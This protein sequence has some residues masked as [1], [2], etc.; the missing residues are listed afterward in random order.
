MTTQVVT[1]TA[2]GTA[3]TTP[4]GTTWSTNTAL[5]AIHTT[6]WLGLCFSPDLGKWCACETAAGH[7]ATSS[8]GIT[9]SSGGIL[10]GQPLGWSDICWSPALGKFCMVSNGHTPNA[11][12]SSDGLTWTT[13]AIGEANTWQKVAWSPSLNLFVAMANSGTHQLATSPDGVTW[14][15]VAHPMSSL[16]TLAWDPI[17][18]L[19]CVTCFST[20]KSATS[21][22]GS[23]WT[24]HTSNTPLNQGNNFDLC[25]IAGTGGFLCGEQGQTVASS[26]D[27]STWTQHA[28]NNGTVTVEALDWCA[29]LSKYFGSCSSGAT[30]GVISS[31]DGSTWATSGT[32]TT[33]ATWVN[34]AAFVAPPIVG[35]KHQF[36]TVVC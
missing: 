32:L 7:T 5:N 30:Q 16:Q 24:A 13:S 36:G 26:T 15:L 10:S 9:W 23:T 22:D 8:D 21:P 27:G 14:T 19:F 18:A 29:G 11:A 34:L 20:N 25:A 6:N 1:I 28:A 2:A 33:A 12:V 31:A 3:A 17:L 4:D 35:F